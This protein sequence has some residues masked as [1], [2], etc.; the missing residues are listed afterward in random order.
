M[1]MKQIIKRGI[2]CAHPH[3][4]GGAFYPRQFIFSRHDWERKMDK[5]R[6]NYADLQDEFY[7]DRFNGGNAD[8]SAV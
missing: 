6:E 5:L 2:D 1:N 3:G 8:L 7:P 4:I